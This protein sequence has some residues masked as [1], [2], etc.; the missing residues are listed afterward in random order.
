MQPNKRIYFLAVLA[1]FLSCGAHAGSLDDTC[2]VTHILLQENGAGPSPSDASVINKRS[3]DAEQKALAGQLRDSIARSNVAFSDRNE[4]PAP[5]FAANRARHH[6]T[7]LLQD[8]VA[9]Y[10]DKYLRAR[11]MTP[12]GL[13]SSSDDGLHG[14]HIKVKDPQGVSINVTFQDPVLFLEGKQNA[15]ITSDGGSESKI[16]ILA[17]SNE[18]RET[19]LGDSFHSR[20][21][22]CFVGDNPS[23]HIAARAISLVPG[24][25][26]R[27]AVSESSRAPASAAIAGGAAR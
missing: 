21:Q 22:A 1:S 11:G 7:N 24:K 26:E 12:E 6:E 10:F 18:A 5:D 20:V 13:F 3:N 9:P 4:A 2:K 19:P 15:E 8:E 23:N 16:E 27:S 25:A 17:S 14:L